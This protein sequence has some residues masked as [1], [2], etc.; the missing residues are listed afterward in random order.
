M[1]KLRVGY[2][3][4][5][6]CFP[7]NMPKFDYRLFT[8]PKILRYSL[9]GSWHPLYVKTTCFLFSISLPENNVIID[10]DS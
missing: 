7:M 1:A 2:C 4:L 10:G 5:S 3:S 6:I 9:R 8:I